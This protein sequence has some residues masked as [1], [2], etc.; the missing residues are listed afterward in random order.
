LLEPWMAQ[1][2]LGGAAVLLLIIVGKA[3]IS[4]VQSQVGTLDVRYAEQITQLRA[5]HKEELARLT[6]SWE[7]RL[8][9]SVAAGKAWE[10][11][12]QR[13]ELAGREDREQVG[14]LLAVTET[15]V[16]LMEALRRE[17]GQR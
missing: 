13:Y 12:A 8:R 15:S 9:D 2:G 3:Y 11:A 7:A 16:Q 17:V 5:D 4:H 1:L 14:K 6:E 10:T